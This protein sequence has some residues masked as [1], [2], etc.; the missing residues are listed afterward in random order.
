VSDGVELKAQQGSFGCPSSRTEVG[1]PEPYI[2]N[3]ELANMMGILKDNKSA[4]S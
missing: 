2:S 1:F 4:T 3:K